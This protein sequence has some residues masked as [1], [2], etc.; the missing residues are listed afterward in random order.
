[1][2]NTKKLHLF[3]NAYCDAIGLA[4][5]EFIDVRCIEDDN[6]FINILSG[7][8]IDKICEYA[9]LKNKIAG[10]GE[11]F[12]KVPKL[13]NSSNYFEKYEIW[14][15]EII[16]ARQIDDLSVKELSGEHLI[17]EVENLLEYNEDYLSKIVDFLAIKNIPVLIKM[18]QTLEEVGKIVNKFNLSPAEVLEDFGFLDRKCY[19]Y[20]LNFLDKEDQKLLTRYDVSLIL[21]P[22]DDGESGRGAINLYNFIFN[23]L[24]FVFSS[25]KCYNIDMFLEGKLALHNTANLMY[26]RGLVEVDDVLISLQSECGQLSIE[27]DE[28]TQKECVLDNKVELNDNKLKTR[29]FELRKEIK[30]IAKKIKEKIQWNLKAYLRKNLG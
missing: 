4:I 2:Q 25:G 16:S 27:L 17:I 29:L 20:G 30:L 6:Y 18:G 23:G 13:N 7:E 9:V 15:R 12:L 8:D 19:I 28:E 5:G 14:G 1:M 24:K 3:K 26:E 10:V 11:L 21:S 22:K